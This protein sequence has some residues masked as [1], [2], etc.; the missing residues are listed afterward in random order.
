MKKTYQVRIEETLSRDVTVKA[1]NKDEA[2]DIVRR[3]YEKEKIVL[4]SGD[5]NH[6]DITIV[7]D[8]GK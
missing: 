4:G 3:E 8:A 1:N 6:L 5:F 2:E 7:G